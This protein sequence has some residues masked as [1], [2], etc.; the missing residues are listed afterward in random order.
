M[1]I[2]YGESQKFI[3]RAKNAFFRLDITYPTKICTVYDCSRLQILARMRISGNKFFK[4][5]YVQK[6]AISAR[7]IWSVPCEIV[8]REIRWVTSLTVSKTV[9]PLKNYELRSGEFL[10]IFGILEAFSMAKRWQSNMIPQNCCFQPHLSWACWK[11]VAEDW[12]RASFWDPGGASILM[13]H[14]VYVCEH[15]CMPEFHR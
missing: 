4:T 15:L 14:P 1:F 8:E 13:K 9:H 3:L 5:A 6:M 10:A 12:W 7:R 2:W 11:W